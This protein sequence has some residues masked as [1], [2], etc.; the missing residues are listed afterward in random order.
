MEQN[1]SQLTLWIPVIS[2]LVGGILV[3]IG[4]FATSWFN[5]STES[6]LARESRDRERL[7]EV[8]EKLV[9]I[10]SEYGEMFCQAINA[11]HHNQPIKV[12]SGEGMPPIIHLQML[13]N[14]YFPRLRPSFYEFEKAKNNFGEEYAKLIGGSFSD[15]SLKEK[16][17]LSGRF[18]KLLDVLQKRIEE[19]QKVASELVKA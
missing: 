9:L 5:K 11:I 13:V 7:E 6:R 1:G 14:L 10:R 2:A 19:M 17:D 3:L 18:A 4:S 12:K 16:K 15:K 8:Y